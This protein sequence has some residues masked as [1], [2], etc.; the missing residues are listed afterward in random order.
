[1]STASL[2]P[3]KPLRRIYSKFVDAVRIRLLDDIVQVSLTMS[4]S[5]A[6]R[7]A[8]RLKGGFLLSTPSSTNEWSATWEHRAM[9][10]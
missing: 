7:Q 2:L 5:T 3:R 1:M 6:S 9:A 4:S 8:K 10:R